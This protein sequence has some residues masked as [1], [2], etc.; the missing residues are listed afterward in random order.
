[1]TAD[2][3]LEFAPSVL[4]AARLEGQNWSDRH[5]SDETVCKLA[6][7]ARWVPAWATDFGCAPF[8]KARLVVNDFQDPGPATNEVV[9][10]ASV[11]R[12][13]SHLLIVSTAGI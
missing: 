13:G 12:K 4:K 2:E 6:L 9:I 7:D 3:E 1:M 8:V 11:A 5:A 10:A